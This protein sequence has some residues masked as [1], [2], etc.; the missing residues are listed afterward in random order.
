[1]VNQKNLLPTFNCEVLTVSQWRFQEMKKKKFSLENK[2]ALETERNYIGS[3]AYS[4][5]KISFEF[6]NQTLKTNSHCI[7]NLF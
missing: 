4:Y 1:M 2:G 3:F 7:R 6:N 5:W